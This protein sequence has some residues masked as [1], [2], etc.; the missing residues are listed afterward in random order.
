MKGTLTGTLKGTLKEA[1]MKG[2]ER[3]KYEGNIKE[4]RKKYDGC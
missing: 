2:N 3:N 4:I 1:N